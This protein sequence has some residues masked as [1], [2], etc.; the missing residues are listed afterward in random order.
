MSR[1]STAYTA[2]DSRPKATV[3]RHRRPCTQIAS[4]YPSPRAV[5][6][7]LGFGGVRLDTLPEP[8]DVDVDD[9]AV[10]EVAVAPD[11]VEQL[12]AAANPPVRDGQLDE[13]AELRAGQRD[14]SI[15]TGHDSVVES[16]GEVVDD[17][18]PGPVVDRRLDPSQHRSYA[19]RQLPGDEWLGHVVVRSGLQ[20]G[21]DVVAVGASRHHDDGHAARASDLTAYREAVDVG[22]H[23][24]EQDD[25]RVHLGQVGEAL[26][27]VGRLDDGEALVLEREPKDAPDSCVVLHEQHAPRHVVSIAPASRPR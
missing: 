20:A 5:T 12:L 24:V 9:A 26:A 18:A 15:G 27:S 14:P 25:V 6:T 21:H 4:R 10:A 1:D 22:E 11:P 19:C 7:Y 17:D 13:E 16:D 3:T 2:R 8:A 23:E